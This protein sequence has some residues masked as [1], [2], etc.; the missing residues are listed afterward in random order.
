MHF[1]T[2]SAIC[3]LFVLLAAFCRAEDKPLQIPSPDKKFVYE[4]VDPDA[5][6]AFGKA[7][8]VSKSSGETLWQSPDEMNNSWVQTAKCI[9]SPDSKKFAVNFRAGGRYETMGIYRWNGK[10]FVESSSP[11]DLLAARLDAIKDR[12]LRELVAN[13]PPSFPNK[14]AILHGSFQRR[15][16]DNFR[17]RRWID[18]NTA[19]VTAYS[20]RTVSAPD[21]EQDGEEIFGSMRFVLRLDAKGQWKILKEQET[22]LEKAQSDNP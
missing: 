3:A 13:L 7:R 21:T 6:A 8:V 18:D 2:N 9:W 5:D 20:E 11:E 22:S 4:F 10:A 19:E 12:Q 16:W 14:D 17:L 15:I 1:P